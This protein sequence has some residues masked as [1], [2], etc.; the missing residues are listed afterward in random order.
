[1][2]EPE[3]SMEDILSSIKDILYDD[4]LPKPQASSD[5]EASKE[6]E[7]DV[8]PKVNSD[9]GVVPEAFPEAEA[10]VVSDMVAE[11]AALSN[12]V[13]SAK[14]SEESDVLELTEDMMVDTA[15][16]KD[17]GNFHRKR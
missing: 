2:S 11:V 9:A 1:M 13:D 17:K 15:E 6:K 5:V 16:T 4:S 10:G 8:S 14:S 3:P 7:A 12:M